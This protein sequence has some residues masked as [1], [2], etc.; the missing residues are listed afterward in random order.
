MS[1]K[2]RSARRRGVPLA[3]I[4]ISAITAMILLHFRSS[5]I[6]ARISNITAMDKVS[7]LFPT[8]NF[9]FAPRNSFLFFACHGLMDEAHCHFFGLS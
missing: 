1:L 6:D 5:Y 9:S 7:S 4:V 3:T 8:F 2:E